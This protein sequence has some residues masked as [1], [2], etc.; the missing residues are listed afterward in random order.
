MLGVFLMNAKTHGSNGSGLTAIDQYK[1]NH[2]ISKL[3]EI[4]LGQI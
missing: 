1:N 2:L 4:L 3:I